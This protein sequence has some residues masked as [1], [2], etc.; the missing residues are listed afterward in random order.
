MILEFWEAILSQILVDVR[1]GC[2]QP[3]A[4]SP[5]L[6]PSAAKAREVME[7]VV[8]NYASLMEDSYVDIAGLESSYCVV[9]PDHG[10]DFVESCDPPNRP[11]GSKLYNSGT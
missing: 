2:S 8:T 6:F 10:D 3:T 5:C 7:S 9:S 4:S 1:A 11:G